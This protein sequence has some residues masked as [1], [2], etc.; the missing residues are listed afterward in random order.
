MN[1]IFYLSQGFSGGGKQFW[2]ERVQ[3]W[4]STS[5]SQIKSVS[6]KDVLSLLHLTGRDVKYVLIDFDQIFLISFS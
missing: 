2:T 4:V 6:E 1:E 3:L 5:N